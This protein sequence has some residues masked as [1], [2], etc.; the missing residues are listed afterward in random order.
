VLIHNPWRSP[1]HPATGDLTRTSVKV[2]V[3][4]RK[5]PAGKI[6]G[7]PERQRNS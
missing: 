2:K 1:I 3:C 7:V 6:A 5:V 4:D